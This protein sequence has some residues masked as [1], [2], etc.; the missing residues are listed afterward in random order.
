[1]AWSAPRSWVA[2]EV[3]SASLLN[4]ELRDNLN[5]AHPVGSL[6]Y[7]IRAAT[8]VQTTINGFSL[9][10]NASTP[11]RATYTALNT[12][13]SGLGYP[14]GTGDGSTTFTLPDLQ[15]RSPV[16]MASGGHTDVNGLGDSDGLAKP[17]RTAKSAPLTGSG[18]TDTAGGHTHVIPIATTSNPSS[19]TSVESA[20]PTVTVAGDSHYHTVGP[21]ATNS[22]GSHSHTVTSTGTTNVPFL[23][24]GV[25]SVKY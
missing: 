18:T 19:I 9:E 17:S 16:A 12:L 20:A 7:Y 14:F 21:W 2:G 1:M 3:L 15:G 23:V 13:L 11:L 22:N 24:A 8:T 6:H 5:A 4:A 10:C 25:Y